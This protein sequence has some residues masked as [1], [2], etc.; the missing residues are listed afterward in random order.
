MKTRGRMALSLNEEISPGRGTSNEPAGG[1]GPR[2]R[3]QF[4]GIICHV[5]WNGV[6]GPSDFAGRAFALLPPGR[7]T[8][9]LQARLIVPGKRG[10]RR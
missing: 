7:G 8:S 2:T 10:V 5:R 4:N 9:D 6:A 3:L 1:R